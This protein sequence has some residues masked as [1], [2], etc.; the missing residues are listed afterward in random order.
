[1]KVEE[2]TMAE[3]QINWTL[4]KNT[5]LVGRFRQQ[6]MR[7]RRSEALLVL[8]FVFL[9]CAGVT[10]FSQQRCKTGI[11]VGSVGRIDPTEG[12]VPLPELSIVLNSDSKE[13]TITS[14]GNGDYIIELQ[15]G[16]YC[17]SSIS[18]KHGQSYSIKS[19]QSRCFEIKKKKDTR[20]DMVVEKN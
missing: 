16:K 18:D 1:M 12:F 2:V 3:E 19:S 20:F 17:I 5:S 15:T 6:S 14:D 4:K 10:A 7:S 8:G 13:K 9:I 11:L